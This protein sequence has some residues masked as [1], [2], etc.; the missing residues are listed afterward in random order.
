MLMIKQYAYI[1]LLLALAACKSSGTHTA[2][3]P[4]PRNLDFNAFGKYWYQGKAELNTYLSLI[5][6]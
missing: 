4:A 6:I 5:H 1:C 2:D 3:N